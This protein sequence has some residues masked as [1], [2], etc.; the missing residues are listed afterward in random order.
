MKKS[1]RLEQGQDFTP[2]LQLLRHHKNKVNTGKQ[3][4]K[5][6]EEGIPSLKKP[7]L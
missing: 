5:E 6:R 7:L 3:N 2:S 4:R 1:H